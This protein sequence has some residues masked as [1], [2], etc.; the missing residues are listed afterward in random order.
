MF[1][2]NKIGPAGCTPLNNND[3]MPVVKV[4]SGDTWR[5]EAQFVAENG[6][7]ATPDNSFVEFVVSENQFSPPLW[8]GEWFSGILPDA[9]RQGL[10]HINIPR[11]VTKT[12]RRGSYMF[13]ARVAD[14]MRFSYDTQL[15]GNFLV[16]YMPTSEQHSIPYRDGTSEIFNGGTHSQDESHGEDDNVLIDES[17][18]KWHLGVTSVG[19]LTTT[20]IGMKPKTSE[21]AESAKNEAL[22]QD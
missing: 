4:I 2:E 22:A 5:I 15:V 10:A 21:L 1:V 12:F 14:K 8:T 20:P 18:G 11:E 16:E 17:G 19:A 3:R 9:N 7:P 13:S 6:G